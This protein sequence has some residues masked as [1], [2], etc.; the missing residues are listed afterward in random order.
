MSLA[1]PPFSG[2]SPR[3]EVKVARFSADPKIRKLVAPT[4]PSSDLGTV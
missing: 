1:L 3:K 4:L 2:S